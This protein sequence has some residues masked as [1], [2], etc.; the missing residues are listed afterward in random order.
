M[1]RTLRDY[2]PRHDYDCEVGKC[3]NCGHWSGDHDQH[4]YGKPC[5]DFAQMPCSCGLELARLEALAEQLR[6][7]KAGAEI[8][9]RF[10]EVGCH[11]WRDRLW[12]DEA[13]NAAIPNTEMLAPGTTTWPDG[14]LTI[15]KADLD[16]G[17]HGVLQA[18]GQGQ[19]FQPAGRCRGTVT[20]MLREQ[21]VPSWVRARLPSIWI[22][23]QLC[24][25]AGLG[26][27][28]Q[29]KTR[30]EHLS[31]VWQLKPIRHL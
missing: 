18:I 17:C 29:S 21:G 3:K 23:D 6:G 24:W 16:Q 20:E 1:T 4:G 12:L 5:D 31:V 26:F 27:S 9:V 8:L 13:M 22:N 19:R 14:Q 10:G 28:E 15:N 11:V 7:A 30:S 2:R 25:V